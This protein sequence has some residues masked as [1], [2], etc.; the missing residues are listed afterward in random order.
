M[1]I[2]IF[3][4]PRLSSAE[5]GP[6]AWLA[7]LLAALLPFLT[8]VI[9][10]R[11][12]RRMPD[13]GFIGM[14]H[15][16]FGR[17]LGSAMAFLFILYFLF[18]VAVEVRLFCELTKIFLLP[19]TPLPVIILLVI[20]GSGY[21]I[22]KGARVV[23][24]L[25][26][27]IFWI[28]L[29][30]LFLIMTPLLDADYTNLLP[31]GEAGL[32]GIAR[33]VLASS[34][35]YAGIEVLLIFYFLVGRKQ[36]VIKAGILGLG[37]T[38]VAYLTVTLVCLMIWGDELMQLIS[39]PTITVLKSIKFPVIERPEFL[40]LAVWMGLGVRPAINLGFCAAYSLSENIH[41][42]RSKFFHLVVLF[43]AVLT[44][45]VALLPS[46]TGAAF[47]WAEYAGYSFLLSSLILPVVMLL[48]A[49]IRRKEA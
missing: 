36:E 30:L 42:D 31:V 38:T 27:I 11:L 43:L 19:R 34:F 25:N 7:V 22:N 29:P 14:N 18:I 5:A 21:A 32:T 15:L 6:D 41:I 44:Y 46:D 2:G 20:A 1:G 12:G 23:A 49:I 16:L 13:A 9:I 40:M 8:L 28:L 10:E 47:T 4:L 48:T 35:S 26:E 33:G 24:R 39:W 37:F 45:I 17:W 3:S